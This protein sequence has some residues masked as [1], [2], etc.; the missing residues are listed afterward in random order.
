MTLFGG[1]VHR[2]RIDLEQNV[3]AVQMLDEVV[4]KIAEISRHLDT[5]QGPALVKVPLKVG[6]G[7]DPA[8]GRRYRDA[9]EFK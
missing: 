2:L 5:R 4:G 6:D 3:T 8:M 1:Q 7:G 9:V